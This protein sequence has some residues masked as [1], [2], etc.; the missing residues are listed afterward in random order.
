MHPQAGTKERPPST[1]K[2]TACSKEIIDDLVSRELP[3]EVCERMRRRWSDRSSRR[4][5]TLVTQLARSRLVRESG[6][7]RADTHD[8]PELTL[9]SEAGYSNA[10]PHQPDR[11]NLLHRTAG[12]Y[13]WVKNGLG[14]MSAPMS[15][16]A[17]KETSIDG[18]QGAIPVID[19]VC[20]TG[21]TEYRA[22]SL[23]Q[24]SLAPENLTTFAH[25]SVSLAIS[26]AKSTGEPAITAQPSSSSRN[27]IFDSAIAALISRLSLP[28]ISSGVSLGAP[29]PYHALASYPATNSAIVGTSGSSATGAA[30]VTASARSRPLLM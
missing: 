6:R 13:S 10:R 20:A 3:A 2:G 17:R 12:P 4:V 22:G 1:N 9:Q 24:S 15:G 19:V 27:L 28:T 11:R 26:F 21:V 14:V 18:R 23:D 25:F 8:G 16:F 30:V 5:R 29:M 7:M